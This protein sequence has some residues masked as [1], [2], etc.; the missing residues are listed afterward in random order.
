V[1]LGSTAESKHDHAPR[2]IEEHRCPLVPTMAVELEPIASDPVVAV[3][4]EF[5]VASCSSSFVREDA[6]S[7]V[8]DGV[9]TQH[10]E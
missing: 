9:R 5:M 8:E 1:Y 7:R 2:F 4:H 6:H 10:I 3:A